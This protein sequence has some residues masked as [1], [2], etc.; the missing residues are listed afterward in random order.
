MTFLI[1]E[2]HIVHPSGQQSPSNGRLSD[3]ISSENGGR[4][5]A[6]VIFC[7]KEWGSRGKFYLLFFIHYSSGGNRKKKKILNVEM[8][9]QI[10]LQ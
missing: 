4:E 7:D 5:D 2:V 9:V 10:R 8:E 3:G 1:H 6:G